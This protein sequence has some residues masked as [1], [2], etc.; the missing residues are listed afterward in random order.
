M[1]YA[2][3]IGEEPGGR[4]MSVSKGRGLVGG[5]TRTQ[6]CTGRELIGLDVR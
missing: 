4:A 2:G 3:N 1:F 6:K 5:G